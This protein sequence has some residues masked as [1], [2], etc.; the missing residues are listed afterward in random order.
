M[1]STI[2]IKSNTPSLMKALSVTFTDKTKVLSEIIQNSRRAN[3]TAIDMV[4]YADD[5][6]EFVSSIAITD[7]G[8]GIDDMQDI[9]TIGGSGWNEA[10]AENENPYGIGSIA[11]LYACKTLNISSG[12][13]CIDVSCDD[14]I[15]GKT[16]SV[17]Q[18]QWVQDGT[19]ITLENTV[20]TVKQLNNALE[21][22]AK[23]SS[24]PIT[25]NSQLLVSD[26]ALPYLRNDLSYTCL[27]TPLGTVAFKG[28]CCNKAI[29]VILQELCVYSMYRSHTLF[30]ANKHFQ[31]RM[32]DRDKLV[33]EKEALATISDAIKLVY[34]EYLTKQKSLYIDD[35]DALH[36]WVKQQFVDIVK[37]APILLNDIDYLPA[38]AF[39]TVDYP[40]MRTSYIQ[41]ETQAVLKNAINDVTYTNV[42][43]DIPI[44]LAALHAKKA[45]SLGKTLDKG[46]WFYEQYNEFDESKATINITNGRVIDSYLYVGYEDV[47]FGVA[48]GLSITYEKWTQTI[49]NGAFL[50]PADF[51]HNNDDDDVFTQHINALT[52]EYGDCILLD[53]NEIETILFQF[54]GFTDENDSH[55]DLTVQECLD[56]VLN[57]ASA[58]F[59]VSA[60]DFIS[61]VLPN[62]PT[63]IVTQ[64]RS[65][66]VTLTVD[67]HGVLIATAA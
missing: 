45:Q 60:S 30:F 58:A 16:F 54:D 10:T 1:S 51:A 21:K 3:A 5:E 13:N 12:D 18:T 24:I 8:S 2:S 57:L 52:D 53:T 11:M 56:E 34:G 47:R 27:D 19:R 33:E 48:D 40:C 23:Y 67:E 17:K 55:D 59:G 61:R 14:I 42:S 39:D 46:H 38:G 26:L 49:N 7:N 4:Y 64:L 15:S 50:R 9:F 22:L 6:N 43:T 41:R 44:F 31:A 63:D 35:T 29:K 66:P 36:E 62:L 32:P 25:V 37:F 28:H 20:F 65:N